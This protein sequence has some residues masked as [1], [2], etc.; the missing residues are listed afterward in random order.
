G[1]DVGARPELAREG[2][3]TRDTIVHKDIQI[4]ALEGER[5]AL[6]VRLARVERLLA[7]RFADRVLRTVRSNA[8]RLTTTLRKRS[9]SKA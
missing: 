7:E 4:R 5:D 8:T 9:R 1:G 3:R 6:V 2:E